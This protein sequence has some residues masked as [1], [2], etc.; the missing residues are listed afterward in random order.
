MAAETYNF[1]DHIKND[2]F[3]GVSF[4]VNVNSSP[5]N[6]TSGNI[7]ASFRRGYDDPRTLITGSGITI[8]NEA[9]GQFRIDSSVINWPAGL[10]NYDIQITLSTGAVKSYIKGTWNIIQDI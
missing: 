2:T 7:I 5:L 6:L 10:Y 1:P 8:T 9:S 3:N 4:T